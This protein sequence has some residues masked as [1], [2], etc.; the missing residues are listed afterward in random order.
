MTIKP[1]RRMMF[2]GTMKIKKITT[3]FHQLEK[4]HHF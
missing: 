4:R 3:K 2:N 1:I